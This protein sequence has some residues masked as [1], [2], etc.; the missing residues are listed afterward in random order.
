MLKAKHLKEL[1]PPEDFEYIERERHATAIHE[2]CHAVAAYHV[3]QYL[4]IDVATIEKGG[5][6][7]GWFVSRSRSRTVFTL[8][9]GARGRHRDLAWRRSPASSMFFDGDNSVG[10][11]RRPPERDP[12]RDAHG[13]LLG[14]GLHDRLARGDEAASGSGRRVSQ[15]RDGHRPAVAQDRVSGGAS[16]RSSRSCSGA[17]R[18]CSSENRSQVLAVTHALEAHKTLSGDDIEAV[19]EG[20]PGPAGRRQRLLHARVRVAEAPSS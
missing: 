20:A 11:R 4:V 3:R 17:P 19:I 12:R 14:H 6:Y 16:R 1:G 15:R 7:L 18:R 5:D 13:G 2:A 8:A 9:V 10:R